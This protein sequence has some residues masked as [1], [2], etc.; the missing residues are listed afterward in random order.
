MNRTLILLTAALAAYAACQLHAARRENARLR[1]TTATL[2]RERDELRAVELERQR[3]AFLAR[4]SADTAP[5]PRPYPE[6][7]YTL[8]TLLETAGFP[9]RRG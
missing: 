1:L 6:R 8:R 3:R 7:T 5:P 9:T 4:L 2:R